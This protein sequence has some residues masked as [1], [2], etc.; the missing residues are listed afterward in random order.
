[1]NRQGRVEEF[2]FSANILIVFQQVTGDIKKVYHVKVSDTLTKDM[3]KKPA[4][5][6]GKGMGAFYTVLNK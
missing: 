6:A 3:T 1:M 2:C 4:K 5:G